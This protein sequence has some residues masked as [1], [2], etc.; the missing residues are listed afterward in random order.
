VLVR[1]NGAHYRKA[2]FAQ[3]ATVAAGRAGLVTSR[4]DHNVEDRVDAALQEVLGYA[5][6]AG[7]DLTDALDSIQKLEFLILLEERLSLPFGDDA[8]AGPW[9]SRREDIVAFVSSA[10]SAQEPDLRRT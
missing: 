6:Q 7:E 3:A 5:P 9:W 2:R 1:R 10:L 8:I 4:D